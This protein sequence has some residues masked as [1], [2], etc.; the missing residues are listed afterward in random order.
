MWNEEQ[1]RGKMLRPGWTWIASGDQG[2]PKG[3]HLRDQWYLGLDFSGEKC[4]AGDRAG[5]V[6]DPIQQLKLKETRGH[7]EDGGSERV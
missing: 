4:W 2:T 3:R 7:G 1:V 5:R 6:T